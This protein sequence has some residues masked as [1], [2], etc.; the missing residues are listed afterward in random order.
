M[1][2]TLIKKRT[3]YSGGGIMPDFFVPLD[4]SEV[5]DYY[6]A[7]IRGGHLNAFTLTYVNKNRLDIFNEYP[8]FKDFK[9]NFKVD[10][11]FMDNFFDYVEKEDA[12]LEHNKKEYQTSEKLLKLRLKA[13]LAQN[14]WGYSEFYQIYNESNE[15]L[16][17]AIEI[18]ETRTYDKADLSRAK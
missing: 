1:H 16:Q 18:L 7:V 9:N 11:K 3:V 15:I 17:K 2:K 4:T 12:E 5:S 13:I 6:G 10:D 14:L 8:E